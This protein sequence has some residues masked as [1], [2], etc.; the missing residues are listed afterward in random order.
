MY[1]QDETAQLLTNP[2]IENGKPTDTLRSRINL[3]QSK[4]T[5]EDLKLSLDGQQV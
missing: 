4:F 5:K 1:W 2:D 3:K